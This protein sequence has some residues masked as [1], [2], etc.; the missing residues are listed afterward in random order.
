[1]SKADEMRE[2]LER[3]GPWYTGILYSPRQNKLKPF[4]TN[5]P[6]RFLDDENNCRRPE[7]NHP[8]DFGVVYYEE[9]LFGEKTSKCRLEELASLSDQDLHYVVTKNNPSLKIFEF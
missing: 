9:F 6:S 1:M 7:E 3:R 2:R 4:S 8:G 5:S